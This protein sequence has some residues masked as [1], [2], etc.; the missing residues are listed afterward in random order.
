MEVEK[1]IP[2]QMDKA[3]YKKETSKTTKDDHRLKEI[4]NQTSK[5]LKTEDK[6]NKL[7]PKEQKILDIF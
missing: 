3:S 2:N 7:G 6:F 4:L 1:H 5:V